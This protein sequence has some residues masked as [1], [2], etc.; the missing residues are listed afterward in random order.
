MR[1]AD[2]CDGQPRAQ[3]YADV[4]RYAPNVPLW[5]DLVGDIAEA[6]FEADLLARYTY[7]GEHEYRLDKA[8]RYAIA[9]VGVEAWLVDAVKAG[10]SR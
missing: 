1:R 8:N 5:E 10:D 3:V 4:Q 7:R 6:A 2:P 9:R